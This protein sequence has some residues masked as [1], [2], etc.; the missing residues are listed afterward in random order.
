MVRQAHHERLSSNAVHPEAVEGCV[1][2][3]VLIKIN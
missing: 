2:C 1:F 3:V